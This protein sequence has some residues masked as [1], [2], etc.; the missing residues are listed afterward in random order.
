MKSS[1]WVRILL[2]SLFASIL[3]TPACNTEEAETPDDMGGAPGG[4]EDNGSGGKTEGTGGKRPTSGG[5]ASS[6]GSEAKSTGGSGQAQSGGASSG[7]EAG[8]SGSAGTVSDE[9]EPR[10]IAFRV[11]GGAQDSLMLARSDGSIDP[12]EVFDEVSPLSEPSWSADGESLVFVE[13]FCCGFSNGAYA[14][15]VDGL[16]VGTPV[17]IHEPL[18]L[19]STVRFAEYSPNGKYVLARFADS[20]ASAR[21]A[22]KHRGAGPGEWTFVSAPALW[23]PSDPDPAWSPDGESVLLSQGQ[24]ETGVI[25]YRVDVDQGAFISSEILSSA[26]GGAEEL[27]ELVWSK[28]SEHFAVGGTH[29]LRLGSRRHSR[30]LL[31]S[32]ASLSNSGPGEGGAS[33]VQEDPEFGPHFPLEFA[34]ES[35]RLIYGSFDSAPSYGSMRLW[36]V[37]LTNP[38]SPE[39]SVLLEREES[40]PIGL[41]GAPYWSTNDSFYVSADTEEPGRHDVLHINWSRK[42]P[43]TRARLPAGHSSHGFALLSGG[44]VYLT[45]DANYVPNRLYFVDHDDSPDDTSLLFEFAE[46]E[47]P[48]WSN[49]LGD[50]SPRVGG[51]FTAYGLDLTSG[52]QSN[53]RLWHFTPEGRL[54]LIAGP[55]EGSGA[56]SDP[57]A[58]DPKEEQFAFT[59]DAEGDY[60]W[61]IAVSQRVNGTFG[62][63][64]VVAELLDAYGSTPGRL[65]WQP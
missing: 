19:G 16:N 26:P 13:Y 49:F 50:A 47:V 3:A 38:S 45:A 14:V 51:F 21:Y 6:G 53:A 10:W 55:L 29:S 15:D 8:S 24:S 27:S 60:F 43:E 48:G 22:L 9:P 4:G 62:E 2:P 36:G 40:H 17:P 20:N 44:L 59:Y 54:E 42:T 7:G 63:P 33:G 5:A 64:V 34:P 31:I 52:Y 35:N 46:N 65:V 25:V 41:W 1:A 28:N 11:R 39:K 30:L 32:D 56:F 61:E 12:F 18:T 58:F 23:N 57:G 37:D